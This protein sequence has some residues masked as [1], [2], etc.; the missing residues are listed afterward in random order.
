MHTSDTG[1]AA[2]LAGNHRNPFRDSTPGTAPTGRNAAATRGR[3]VQQ[4]ASRVL[5]ALAMVA[6]TPLVAA[7]ELMMRA[8]C[9]SSVITQNEGVWPGYEDFVALASLHHD[10]SLPTDSS[11]TIVGPLRFGSLRVTKVVSA[12]SIA[13]LERM[14]LAAAC[15]DVSILSLLVAGQPQPRALWQLDLENATVVLHSEWEAPEQELPGDSFG[16]WP[17]QITWTY[18]RADGTPISH[19]WTFSTAPP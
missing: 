3:S 10:L 14:S 7:S 13:L 15:E 17:E 9:N 12:S 16:F 6:V 5:L 19:S 11:G 1:S 2:G 8:V 4:I 18:F